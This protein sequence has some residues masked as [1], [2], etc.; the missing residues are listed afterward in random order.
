MRCFSSS[1]NAVAKLVSVA[2]LGKNLLLGAY[3]DVSQFA[4]HIKVEEQS[5]QLRKTRIGIGVGTPARLLQLIET[6]E[7]DCLL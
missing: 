7:T 2:E 6:G 1:G 5:Q 3:A 4:K